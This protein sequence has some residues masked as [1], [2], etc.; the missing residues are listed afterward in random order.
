VAIL[1]A[2]YAGGANAWAA[3]RVV[4]DVPEPCH[5]YATVKMAFTG[6]AFTYGYASWAGTSWRWAVHKNGAPARWHDRDIEAAFTVETVTE[7]IKDSADLAGLWF[8]GPI[9]LPQTAIELIEF[10]SD[11]AQVWQGSASGI[12]RRGGHDSDLDAPAGDGDVHRAPG[13]TGP[14]VL[15]VILR[16]RTLAMQAGFVRP[17]S[18]ARCCR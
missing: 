3:Q 9:T 5:V 17:K 7:K 15:R 13:D 16:G 8:G 11:I 12:G 10:V 6:D 2:A 18:E 4:F 14:L 1:A